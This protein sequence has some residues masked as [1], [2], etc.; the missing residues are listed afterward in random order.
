MGVKKFKRI[1]AIKTIVESLEDK[2][3]IVCNLGFPSRELYSLK[4]SPNHFFMLGSMGLASSIGLGLALAQKKKKIVVIDGDGSILMNLGSLATITFQSPPNLIHIILDNKGYGSTGG[5]P[6][7]TANGIDLL[8]IAH[9]MGL[10]KRFRID[11]RESLQS[12]LQ[13]CLE[14]SGPHFIWVD[15]ESG[16]ANVPEI[17]LDPVMISE[18]FRNHAIKTSQKLNEK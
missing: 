10:K 4:D 12:L 3:L 16:N 8:K 11:Q 2:C 17:D 13:K 14:E 6:T 7:F 18:R 5:Q 1:D 15:I 9:G